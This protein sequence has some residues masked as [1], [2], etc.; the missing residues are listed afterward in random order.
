MARE[1]WVA[2]CETDPFLKGRMPKP[3]LWGVYDGTE[4]NEFSDTK[5]FI[6]FVSDKK[7]ILYAHNGGKFD[8]HFILDYLEAFSP[9]QI[10]NGRIAKFKIGLCEFRDSYNILPIPLAAYMK[11]KIDYAIFEESERDKPENKKLITEYLQKDCVY[12]WRLVDQFI[13][14]Y[15]LSLTLAGAAMK[16]WQ[17]IE[18][19]RAPKTSADFYEYLKPFYYGGRVECFTKGKF[20]LPFKVIDVNSAYPNAMTYNHPY[21]INFSSDKKLTRKNLERAFIRLKCVSDGAFPYRGETGLEF[22]SD[23]TPREYCVTG[24]EFIAAE[25]LNLIDRVQILECITFDEYITFKKYVEHFFKMKKEA[26]EKGDKARYI[27]AKLMQNALYGKFC[28]NPTEYREYMI[29]DPQFID[30]CEIDEGYEFDGELGKWALMSKPLDFAKQR[31]YNIAVGA[32]ITGFQ[33]AFLLRALKS[34]EHPLYCDTDSIACE[35]TGTLQLS[36]ELGDWNLEADCT[37][38]AIAGK[39]LYAF[40]L[41]KPKNGETHK[42]ASKGVRLSA[43]EIYKIAEGEEILYESDVPTFS[44]RKEATFLTRKINLT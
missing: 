26:K 6:D 22:P 34:V 35:H 38:G 36:G 24:W 29:I 30:A 10:I 37:E 21:G 19:V 27:F 11:E 1:I 13:R 41:V 44:F 33:R 4:Y 8:W 2:D 42:I 32:S 25:Q 7:V 3:F 18:D 28:A 20:K 16:E 40:K 17:K 9:I 5:E 12:L 39:K 14:D 43:K 23:R 15:G 31:F